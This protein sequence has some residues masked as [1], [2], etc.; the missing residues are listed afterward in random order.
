VSL[1]PLDSFWDSAAI[2][3]KIS[4][5]GAVLSVL[6]LFCFLGCFF[7]WFVKNMWLFCVFIGNFIAIFQ[8]LAVSL[9]PLDSFWDSA[10]IGAKISKIGAALSVLWLFCFWGVPCIFFLWFVKKI[11]AFCVFLENLIV[12][13]QNWRCFWH[14][15]ICF[16]ILRRLVEK[17]LFLMAFSE[18]FFGHG[19]TLFNFS[20]QKKKTS[21][22]KKK[23]AITLKI[24]IYLKNRY[25]TSKI[26]IL[27]QI[28]SK[29]TILPIK[30][31]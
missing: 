13:F 16:K 27:H 9:V 17:S 25:F 12:I 8:N 28:L 14:R 6:W 22:H 5:I 2:G 11:V 23:N 1:V 3:A 31:H 21:R 4:K 10:A 7:W 30:N 29:I 24:A 15:W 18:F 20:K 26:A 19:L